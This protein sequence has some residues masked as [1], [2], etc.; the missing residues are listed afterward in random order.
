[1]IN[2]K[3]VKSMNFVGKELLS[4]KEL[5]RLNYKNREKVNTLAKYASQ[6]TSVYDSIAGGY[7]LTNIVISSLVFNRPGSLY[8]TVKIY[9]KQEGVLFKSVYNKEL[10][11]GEWIDAKDEVLSFNFQPDKNGVPSVKGFKKKSK[12]TENWYY[13]IKALDANGY[14]RTDA[15]KAL[16]S[17]AVLVKAGKFKYNTGSEYDHFYAYRKAVEGEEANTPSGNIGVRPQDVEK[18]RAAGH[19]VEV[20]QSLKSCANCSNCKRLAEDDNSDVVNDFTTLASRPVSALLDE[21]PVQPDRVCLVRLKMMDVEASEFIN[22]WSKEDRQ[23]YY[24]K[25]GYKR[26]LKYDEM[27]IPKYV[28][29]KR[30]IIIGSHEEEDEDGDVMEV[31]DYAKEEYEGVEEIAISFD[32]AKAMRMEADADN[33]PFWTKADSD[34]KF[35]EWPKAD[36]TA[37]LFPG[38]T[39]WEICETNKQARKAGKGFKFALRYHGL[40]AT[41]WKKSPLERQLD[42]LKEVENWIDNPTETDDTEKWVKRFN[43]EKP[44]ESLASRWDEVLNRFADSI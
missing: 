16:L 7:P 27:L 4:E 15:L 19:E 32:K 1:M 41:Y 35:Y 9:T 44:V 38:E 28:Y 26:Y 11:K 6:K 18:L 14:P 3:E 33:C 2:P 23:T 37:V 29:G 31:K 36:K 5:Y 34:T 12:S 17:A 42:F 30:D 24:T 25:E 39:E 21:G 13:I 43:E 22:E 10:G 20:R 8:G 40:E